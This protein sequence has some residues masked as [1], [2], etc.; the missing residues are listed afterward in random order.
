MIVDSDSNSLSSRLLSADQTASSDTFLIG[1]V[2]KCRGLRHLAIEELSCCIVPIGMA[3]YTAEIWRDQFSKAKPRGSVLELVL[4]ETPEGFGDITVPIQIFS[5][6]PE[7]S[8]RTSHMG[9]WRFKGK[10]HVLVFCMTK[11]R[12]EEIAAAIVDSLK[13]QRS[14]YSVTDAVE[15][16]EGKYNEK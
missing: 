9:C 15:N 7:S 5:R 10:G 2:I 3:P 4:Y 16:L 8:A 14:A 1:Y 6:Q 12:C 13:P 11:P